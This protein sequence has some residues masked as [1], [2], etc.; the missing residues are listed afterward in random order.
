[1]TTIAEIALFTAPCHHCRHRFHPRPAQVITGEVLY[2][3]ACEYPPCQA[4]HLTRS[5]HPAYGLHLCQACA[6]VAYSSCWRKGRYGADPGTRSYYDDG[7][8]LYGYSCP[9]CQ[10]WHLTKI[11]SADDIP[12]DYL[13]RQGWL[14]ELINRL[15]WRIDAAR[16]A[17]HTI[18]M[19]DRRS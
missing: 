12:A 1:M 14:G 16:A 8:P 17:H 15:G 6:Q 10:G 18:P 4:C 11:P 13:A 19:E 3:P 2:C 7:H 5:N 9:L